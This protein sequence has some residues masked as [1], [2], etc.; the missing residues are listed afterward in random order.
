LV[1]NSSKTR[2]RRLRIKKEKKMHKKNK[3][4]KIKRETKIDVGQR[5]TRMFKLRYVTW[6][7]DAGHTTTLHLRFKRGSIDHQRLLLGLI[8]TR[9]LTFGALPVP[10]LR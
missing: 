1:V 3:K 4:L 2:S 9:Q 5:S 6:E 8:I 7:M 10:F